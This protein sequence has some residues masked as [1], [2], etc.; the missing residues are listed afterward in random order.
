MK[1]IEERREALRSEYEGFIQTERGKEWQKEWVDL[2]GNGDFS[3]YL[4]DFYP[5]LLT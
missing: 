3:D 5:E 1:S 4:Y 2:E